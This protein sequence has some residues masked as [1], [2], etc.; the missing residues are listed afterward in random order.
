MATKHNWFDNIEK[1]GFVYSFVRGTNN[2]FCQ[3]SCIDYHS[4]EALP[5]IQQMNEIEM[6]F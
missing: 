1:T 3:F 2:H 6:Y 4:T 5:A